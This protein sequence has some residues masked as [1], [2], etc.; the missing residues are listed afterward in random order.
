MDINIDSVVAG[1]LGEGKR[2]VVIPGFG[3]LI[4]RPGGE[5][6]FVDIL[7][8][9]DGVLASALRSGTGLAE[10]AARE[11]VG[12]YSF[13]LK[14]ELLHKREVVIDGVGIIRMTPDGCYDMYPYEREMEAGMPGSMAAGEAETSTDATQDMVSGEIFPPLENEP[15]ISL[16]EIRE[17][18]IFHSENESLSATFDTGED[19]GSEE[20]SEETAPASGKETD[21][22]DL[23]TVVE[24]TD[25]IIPAPEPG[26]EEGADPTPDPTSA[27]SEPESI[28]EAGLPAGTTV[29]GSVA[30]RVPMGQSGVERLRDDFGIRSGKSERELI[31]RLLYDDGPLPQAESGR[32]EKAVGYGG[33]PVN[34]APGSSATDV[35]CEVFPN[36]DEDDLL[37]A[38]KKELYAAEGLPE[39]HSTPQNIQI[40]R[41]KKKKVDGILVIGIIVLVLAVAAI[42]YGEVVK[43]G[44]E[45]ERREMVIEE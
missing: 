30:G 37:R 23:E 3:A 4:R 31:R 19:S 38:D 42:V 12:K 18:R 7:N 17:V 11:A 26:R 24:I 14:T 21:V 27:K 8:S 10:E 20:P 36:T 15:V 5:I 16:Q 2:R 28:I 6:A 43:K 29:T 22:T 45:L 25:R 33:A 32:E 41:P 1:C 39:V 35:A 40:R 13:H 9:D 44:I 34:G